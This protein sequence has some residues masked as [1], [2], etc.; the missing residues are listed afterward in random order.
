[1]P[2]YPIAVRTRPPEIEGNDPIVEAPTPIDVIPDDYAK[3]LIQELKELP[4]AWV[5]VISRVL[6][7]PTP[8]GFIEWRD[9]PANTRI[10]YVSSE[11][12]IATRAA[13]ARIGVGVDFEVI[14]TDATVE[15]CESLCRL[16]LKYFCNGQWSAMVAMQWGDCTRRSGMELG[17]AKKGSVTD[18]LKKCLHEFGWAMD[19]YSM[20]PVKV[21]PPDPEE[22]HLKNL[23]TLYTIGSDKGLT[24]VHMAYFISINTKGKVVADL[25]PADITSLKRRLQKMTEEDIKEVVKNASNNSN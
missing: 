1:M 11:Y 2:D 22:M 10:A 7:R 14:K 20:A 24:E 4:Q 19:V 5:Y 16:T 12:A 23:E 8:E 13:L 17:S 18:G 21:P 3:E 15:A 6:N 9:G 25:G